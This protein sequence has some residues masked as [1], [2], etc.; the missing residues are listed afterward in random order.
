MVFYRTIK[1]EKIKY[2]IGFSH[3]NGGFIYQ[4][5]KVFK[6]FRT[7]SIGNKV[8][9]IED[10]MGQSFK[11]KI[12]PRIYYGIEGF[13]SFKNI[14]GNTTF[15]GEYFTGTQ[16]AKD[17]DTRSPQV[18]P[19]STAA[20]YV[21]NFNAGYVYLIHRI[22]T[23]KHELAI[24]YEWYDPNTKI[25][26]SDLNGKNGMKEGEIKF[27]MVDIGYNLYLTPNVKFLVHYNMVSN[28]VTKIKGFNRDLKDNIFTLRMQYRF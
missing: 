2:G 21:R 28:E 9:V 1:K 23:S 12:A 3:Y 18:L 14:L 25:K 16:A 26:A 19:T 4:N 24:K 5:N 17:N 27:T 7:D 22:L 15:R 11:N 13:F 10:T 8:W 6:S 20:M